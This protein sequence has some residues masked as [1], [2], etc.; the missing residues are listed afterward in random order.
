[1]GSAALAPATLERTAIVTIATTNTTLTIFMN[2]LL[3][4]LV[5]SIISKEST[6]RLWAPGLIVLKQILFR[7]VEMIR[8]RLN[9]FFLVILLDRLKDD[10]MFIDDFLKP[11][12]MGQSSPA[13]YGY[14]VP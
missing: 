14:E 5:R 1:M 12:S 2:P 8:N 3:S 13:E 4:W 11:L 9:R 10:L 6:A 7:C